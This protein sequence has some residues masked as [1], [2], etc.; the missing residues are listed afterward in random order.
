MDVP[1]EVLIHN[2]VVGWKGEEGTLLQIGDGFYEVNCRFGG[3]IHR[4][5]L[6]MSNTVLIA[7]D[8]EERFAA[9][10]DIER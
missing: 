1:S 7:K 5:L 9:D 8:R 3:S 10:V 2:T 6:P 4:V